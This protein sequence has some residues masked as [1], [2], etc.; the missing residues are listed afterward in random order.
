VQNSVLSADVETKL[1]TSTLGDGY[2]TVVSDS[3]NTYVDADD[4]AYK[5]VKTVE[6]TSVTW[7]LEKVK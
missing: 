4:V 6:K 7:T 3:G 2:E 1:V 5:F